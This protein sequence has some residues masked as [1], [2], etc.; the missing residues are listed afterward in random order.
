MC[1]ETNFGEEEYTKKFDP[2]HKKWERNLV[3]E[4][5]LKGY[6]KKW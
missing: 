5:L 2:K 1:F 3:V 4:K 6:G